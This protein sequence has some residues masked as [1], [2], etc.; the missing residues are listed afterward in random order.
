MPFHRDGHGDGTIQVGALEGSTGA[1]LYKFSMP[2][3]V[4]TTICLALR[5][6]VRGYMTK[7]FGLEDWLII[8]AYILFMVLCICVIVVGQW[9]LREDAM[10]RY[11]RI[12]KLTI[13]TSVLF[14][15]DQ[16]FIKLSIAAYFY[17]FCER[18]Q[19][20]I[21]ICTVSIFT[22]YNLAFLFVAVFQCGVPTVLNLVRPN[23]DGHC[24]NWSQIVKPLLYVG[25]SLNA[26]C[27]W[28]FVLAC[29]P[30]LAKLRRMPTGE[31]ACLCFL[32]FLATGASVLSLVR[33]RYIPGGGTDVQL[34]KHNQ[35]FAVLSFTEAGTAIVTVCMA[36]LHPL[37]KA[38]VRKRGSFRYPASS[39]PRK[40]DSSEPAAP[41]ACASEKT[42]TDPS[43]E[44]LS[45]ERSSLGRIGI[46]PTIYDTEMG[47][48]AEHNSPR[49]G[50]TNNW[51]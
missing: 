40:P 18:C 35:D 5:I 43:S 9:L 46:L 25:V 42:P 48:M 21:I 15:L 27:D 16:I 34:L 14:I 13:G 45:T 6:Y 20:F 17:R 38:F 39:S 7:T 11:P 10:E 3:M 8:P 29:L 47:T 1:D 32:I 23:T 26:I 31:M 12:I 37:F 50:Y 19:R 41:E 33:I 30:V 51:T 2:L 44:D 28:V 49:L 24:I 22:L 36:T 4:L